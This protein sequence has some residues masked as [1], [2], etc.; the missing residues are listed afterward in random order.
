M[1]KNLFL[2]AVIFTLVI[3]F[4]ANAQVPARVGWWKFDDA[5]NMLKAEIGTALD[6]SGSQTSVDGPAVGNKATEI[7]VGNYLSMTHGISP[8]GGGTL[9]NEY[10]LQIDFAVPEVGIWH[11]FFQ[12]DPT[13]GEDAD[14]FSNSSSNAIGTSQTTYSSKGI[15]AN[16][17]YRMLVTVRNGEFFKVYINGVLWLDAPDQGLD[18]RF[19]LADIL[20]IFADNDGDDGTIDC[21]ELGIW[22]IALDADQVAGL[23]DATGARPLSRNRLGL[24]KFDD[25]TNLLK[26]DIGL[27][28][29]LVGAQQSVTGPEAG[30]GATQIGIGSYLKLTNGLL[31][32]GGGSMV[33]EYSIQMDFSVPEVDVWHTFYQ[34]EVANTTDGE[35]FTN[36]TG[37]TVGNATTGYSSKGITAN[38]W[39]RM[40]ITVKNGSFYKIYLNGVLWLDAPGQPVDGRWGLSSAL[41]LFGD[42][43]GDDGVINCSE[44][45]IW[46]CALTTDEVLLLGTDPSNK[47]PTRIGWWKFDDSANLLKAEIG[48][49]LELTGS[50]L[51]EYGP[52]NGNGATSIG[53]GSYYTMYHGISPNVDGLMVNEYSLQIDFSLPE[54]SIW[55]S[56][57]QTDPA[58]ASDGDFFT[59]GGTS[60]PN[61]IGTSATGYSTKA[62]TT[63]TWYR[64]V[65][66][67]KNGSFFKLYIDG[68]LWLDAAGQAIDG[69][70]ALA[71]Q[72][73]VFADEDGEDGE[74]ICSE[75]GIWDIALNPDQVT[76]L[77]TA[78]TTET[79]GIQSNKLKANSSDLGPNYPNP[80]RYST[81]FPYQ[82]QKAGNVSFRI[83][84]M[85]GN[86][87][88]VISSGMKTTGN[89]TLE[90]NS[91]KLKNGIY[92]IQMTS[93]QRTSIRKMVVIQ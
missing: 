47:L 31:A 76:K 45:G 70:W 55:H 23:G 26:A 12:T 78:T 80:F 4:A 34:T 35:L 73:L 84:D 77:G 24:W 64:M 69:R 7:G 14:L 82:V 32:N 13:N 79:T 18:G 92:Y 3:N 90:L 33:N 6:I 37:N 9:V 59:N 53:T 21:S 57:F 86:E 5:S 88:Q 22:D 91:E 51:A 49:D 39:Y 43:D 75:L 16:T 28:L 85:A 68:E 71:D 46:E 66:T 56:F 81:T 36:K 62:V 74:I 48:S 2:I 30:N 61:T 11:S 25:A 89:Y 87:V 15:T 72:L 1:K 17:W 60:I 50:Q 8:N 40:V 67:V 38:T 29:E 20:L 63:G 54:E 44:V 93:D 65:L 83:L 41:L 42:N 52:V 19:G 58:N 10:S 27:P